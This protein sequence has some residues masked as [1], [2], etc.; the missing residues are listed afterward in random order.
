MTGKFD[1]IQHVSKLEEKIPDWVVNI[2]KVAKEIE[3]IANDV[4]FNELPAVVLKTITEDMASSLDNKIE[5]M[6]K[7]YLTMIFRTQD[8]I[9]D[10]EWETLNAAIKQA[11]V[12][13]LKETVLF[14]E[15]RETCENAA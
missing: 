12:N 3:N 13:T 8:M 6:P 5:T 10:G 1:F 14:I 2:N 15:G 11:V 4:G 9:T 7:Y